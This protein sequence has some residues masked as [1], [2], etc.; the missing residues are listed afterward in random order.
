MDIL[1]KN[2]ERSTDNKKN[3]RVESSRK[4]KKKEKRAALESDDI[5][6]QTS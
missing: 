3:K 2:P 1:I 6:M 4:G 5:D